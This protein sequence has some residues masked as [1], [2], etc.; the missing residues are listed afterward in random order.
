MSLESG[1]WVGRIQAIVTGKIIEANQELE[2]ESRLI[3]EDPYGE[4]WIAKVEL[5]DEPQD[6]LKAD[7]PEFAALID[8]EKI[9]YGK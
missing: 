2:W 3:N 8:A 6:L 7:A 1:K 4:G 5:S 9:K